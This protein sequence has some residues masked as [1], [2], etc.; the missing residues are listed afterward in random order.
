MR[1]KGMKIMEN[2]RKRAVIKTLTALLLILAMIFTMLP[3]GVRAAAEKPD[4]LK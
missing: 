1:K 4:T 2:N 3:D